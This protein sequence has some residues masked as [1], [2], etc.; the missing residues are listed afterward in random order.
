[1]LET[2]WPRGR[3]KNNGTG[4]FY[5]GAQRQARHHRD[6]GVWVWCRT[7]GVSEG[8]RGRARRANTQPASWPPL[9]PTHQF[10]K[11]AWCTAVSLCAPSAAAALA[12]ETTGQA[13]QRRVETSATVYI[14]KR[15]TEWCSSVD[16]NQMSKCGQHECPFF[17]PDF[18]KE[19]P[20]LI[21]SKVFIRSHDLRPPILHL[22]CAKLKTLSVVLHRL[23]RACCKGYC[24]IVHNAPLCLDCFSGPMDANIF[25]FW[26]CTL[27]TLLFII[28]PHNKSLELKEQKKTKT[29]KQKAQQPKENRNTKQENKAMKQLQYLFPVHFIR[30]FLS[31]LQ[32]DFLSL[33]K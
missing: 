24:V 7:A 22:F 15:W 29:G 30:I 17:G 21:C 1:M 3:R 2:L 23:T 4:Y 20:F 19:R 18:A 6:A 9:S 31:L 5:W 10:C 27:R 28:R 13:R 8:W 33:W 16:H 14:W 25:V 12:T 32:R 26:F 11:S